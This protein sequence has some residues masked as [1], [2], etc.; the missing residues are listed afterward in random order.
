MITD[1]Q[2][3]DFGITSIFDCPEFDPELHPNHFKR[4][5]CGEGTD[6]ESALDDL[7]EGLSVLRDIT[8]LEGRIKSEW[9]PSMEEGDWD[10]DTQY[11]FGIMF[12]E[13]E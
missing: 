9:N 3:C 11:K 13:A 5:A 7:L 12:N 8:G 6:A 10:E 2:I 1:F 4:A